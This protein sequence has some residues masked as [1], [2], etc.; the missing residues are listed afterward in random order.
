MKK[1]SSH[2]NNATSKLNKLEECLRDNPNVSD[3]VLSLLYEIKDN[4]LQHRLHALV[5]EE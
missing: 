2:F 4:L 3:D 5:A 1:E